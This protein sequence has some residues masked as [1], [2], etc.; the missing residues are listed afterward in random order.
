MLGLS[1]RDAPQNTGG[2]QHH[3]SQRLLHDHLSRPRPRT[4][5]PRQRR[6]GERA[7]HTYPPA[8]TRGTRE[9]TGISR[10]RTGWTLSSNGRRSQQNSSRPRGARYRSDAGARPGPLRT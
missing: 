10:N 6:R 3:R 5:T 7:S 8:S 1:H 4:S 9:R 2:C